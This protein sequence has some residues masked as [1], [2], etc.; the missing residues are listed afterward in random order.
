LKSIFEGTVTS[1]HYKE[2]DRG[3]KQINS[4]SRLFLAENPTWTHVP[5]SAYLLVKLLLSVF[6]QERFRET[7]IGEFELKIFPE[8][9]VLRF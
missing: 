7:E 9:D 3:R 1:V 2:Y 8:Q 4:F 6:L 5:L